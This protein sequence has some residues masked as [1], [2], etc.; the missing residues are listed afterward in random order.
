MKPY[1]VVILIQFIYTGMPIISKAALDIG[2]S[3][4]VFVFYRQAF[5]TVM[6]VPL[7]IILARYIYDQ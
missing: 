6:L 2:L 5:A 4:F 7:S 1:I 3:P